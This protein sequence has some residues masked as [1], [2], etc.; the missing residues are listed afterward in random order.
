MNK[1]YISAKEYAEKYNLHPRTV[2]LWCAQGRIEG[3]YKFG[4]SWAV[5]DK[6]PRPADKR[7]KNGEW[8]GYRKRE[9]KTVNNSCGAK[10]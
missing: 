6:A 8:V 9:R 4:A 7:Y 1:N 10:D 3:A 2:Q 5:P